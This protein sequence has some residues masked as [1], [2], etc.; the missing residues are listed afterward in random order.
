MDYLAKANEWKS[1]KLLS[2]EEVEQLN[3]M[4]EQEIAEAFYTNLTF[5]T[6]GMRGIMGMGPNRMNVVTISKAT[7]GFARYLLNNP[8]GRNI[9][10]KNKNFTLLL[11]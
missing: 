7:L 2:K 9:F 3:N 5:G 1:C 10:W 6:G 8:F 4:S 11:L